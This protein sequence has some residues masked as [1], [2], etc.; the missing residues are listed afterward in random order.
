M[1][2]EQIRILWKD[3]ETGEE[4]EIFD[5]TTTLSGL[6]FMTQFIQN[7]IKKTTESKQ[8]A[9]TAEHIERLDQLRKDTI[10]TALA[11]NNWNKKQTAE[12]LGIQRTTLH[13]ITERWRLE[14]DPNMQSRLSSLYIKDII[15][16]VSKDLIKA[17]A[18]LVANEIIKEQQRVIHGKVSNAV[19]RTDDLR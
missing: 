6:W 4:K 13:E 5:F 7:Q 1:P 15:E 19:A 11:Q 2:T 9:I 18:V 17:E 3:L 16:E 12:K 14:A 10:L 8:I